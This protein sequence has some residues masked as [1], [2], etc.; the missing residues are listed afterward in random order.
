MIAISPGFLLLGCDISEGES[1][2]NWPLFLGPFPNIQMAVG[3]RDQILSFGY[4]HFF[5]MPIANFH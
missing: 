4:L 5:M 2:L 1:V 3:S